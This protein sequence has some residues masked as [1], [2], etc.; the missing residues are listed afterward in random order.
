MGLNCK[1]IELTRHYDVINRGKIDKYTLVKLIEAK[2]KIIEQWHS[3]D[4]PPPPP[5]PPR[6]SVM[7]GAFWVGKI[8]GGGYKFAGFRTQE[9][10]FGLRVAKFSRGGLDFEEGKALFWHWKVP[11]FKIIHLQRGKLNYKSYKGRTERN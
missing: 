9:G 3:F 10:P 11:I 8:K 4:N 7:E 6:P 1:T 5:P 2:P